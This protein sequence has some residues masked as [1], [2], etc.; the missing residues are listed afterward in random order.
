MKNLCQKV[1]NWR[2]I[3]IWAAIPPSTPAI[4][5]FAFPATKNE[6]RSSRAAGDSFSNNVLRFNRNP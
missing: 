2:N 5:A 1:I 4:F 3:I 6:L